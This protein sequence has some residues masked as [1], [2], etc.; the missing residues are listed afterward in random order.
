M[1][2]VIGEPWTYPYPGDRFEREPFLA[3]FRV[4]SLDFVLANIYVKPGDAV[5]EIDALDDVH[6]WAK[7]EFGDTDII[8]LGDLNADCCYFKED[9]QRALLDMN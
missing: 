8:V 7:A 1:V 6:E 9:M 5:A 2:D 3:R 4:G